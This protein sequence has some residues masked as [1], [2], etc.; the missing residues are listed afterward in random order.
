MLL[1]HP[2]VVD[3]ATFGV[4]HPTLGEDVV[5]AVVLRAPHGVKP[6]ELRDYALER[7]T[8]FKVPTRIVMVDS[9]PRTALGKVRRHELG[10]LFATAL[11]APHAEPRGRHEILVAKTFAEVLGLRRVGAHDNFFELGGDSL[12][13]AQVIG[14]IGAV[15]GREFTPLALFR[16]PT[17]AEF[18]REIAGLM[19]AP[20]SSVP[21]AIVPRQRSGPDAKRTIRR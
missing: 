17:V 3:A 1:G 9:I 16:R 2:A 14:R 19:R 8:A 15:L 10:A 21:P 20:R 6:Q 13:G 4:G 18:A 5:A 12:R 11:Q 7:L